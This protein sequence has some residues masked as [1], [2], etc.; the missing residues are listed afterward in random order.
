MTPNK[1]VVGF[2]NF[3]L[4]WNVT[5]NATNWWPVVNTNW[6]IP[7]KSRSKLILTFKIFFNGFSEV[8]FAE[9]LIKQ[10]LKYAG[11][12]FLLKIKTYPI[13]KVSEWTIL[14][15][16]GLVMFNATFNNISVI[17]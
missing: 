5:L 17:S 2:L 16:F 10:K 6:S 1:K 9:L 15:W 7:T 8:Y 11:L 12:C 4:S 14:A 13:Y 3:A